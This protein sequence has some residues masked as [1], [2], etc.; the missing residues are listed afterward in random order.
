MI[1]VHIVW[2]TSS[3][4]AE[5]LKCLNEEDFVSA[6]NAALVSTTVHLNHVYT[7]HHLV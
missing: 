1:A 4:H 7:L 5:K 3:E 6:V 2:S